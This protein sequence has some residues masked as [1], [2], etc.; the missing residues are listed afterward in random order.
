MG[1]NSIVSENRKTQIP[2][3][4]DMFVECYEAYP[5]SFY[6]R[7]DLELSNSV[8]LPISAL[9]ELSNFKNIKGSKAPMLFKIIN[10]DLNLYTFCGVLEFTAEPEICIIPSNMFDRL[11][12][13]EGQKIIISL[14]TLA[15]GKFVK[16]R[17]RNKEIL[18]YPKSIIEHNL[19][20][21]FCLTEGD[22]ISINYQKKI[23]K[24][25]ILECKPN[26]AIKILNC[27]LEIEL[28]QTFSL[29][30][31]LKNNYNLELILIRNIKE[32]FLEEFKRNK[33]PKYRVNISG[34]NIIFYSNEEYI[35]HMKIERLKKNVNKFTGHCF[36]LD[37]K[38]IDNLQKEKFK[39]IDRK[40]IDVEKEKNYNPRLNRIQKP[41]LEFKFIQLDF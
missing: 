2:D 41:R 5:A 33:I 17:P 4:P 18:D 34:Y 38:K 25:D 32:N 20:N 9:I 30:T 6:E 15:T 23:H 36:R 29:F 1:K 10:I 21:Y 19:R 11:C 28:E 31:F 24:F 37:G 39:N 13:K 35:T 27:D 14:V 26:K 12:L 8:I 7:N 40:N 3:I 22:T 16:M